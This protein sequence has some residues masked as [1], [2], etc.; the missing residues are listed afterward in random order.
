MTRVWRRE[1]CVDPRARDTGSNG[2]ETQTE[3]TTCLQTPRRGKS[4]AVSSR[5]RSANKRLI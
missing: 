4:D 2:I 1:T 3:S 5:M